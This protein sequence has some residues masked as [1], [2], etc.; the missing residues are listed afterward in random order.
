MP[1]AK[2]IRRNSA[3]RYRSPADRQPRLPP[4]DART[5]CTRLRPP[6]ITIQSGDTVAAV[7]LDGI[8]WFGVATGQVELTWPWPTVQVKV[9]QCIKVFPARDVSLWPVLD[10]LARRPAA[11]VIDPDDP[12]TAPVPLPELLTTTRSITHE[13]AHYGDVPPTRVEID[14]VLVDLHARTVRV[15]DRC[16]T[17][18][19]TEFDILS[20]LA[21]HVGVAVSRE[22][23]TEEVWNGS[24]ASTSNA[25]NMHLTALR[26][27]LNRPKLLRTIRG[28]GYRLG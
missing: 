26:M 13:A 21:G 2:G 4:H 6:P 25:L 27:K 12:P 22:L 17:L 1:K 10:T 15:A 18:T 19:N 28:F 3:Q 5:N 9:E 8:T 23:I 24:L 14:D 20:V 11:P 7:D 16:I